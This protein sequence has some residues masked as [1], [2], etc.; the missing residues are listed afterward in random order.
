MLTIFRKTC[1]RETQA[2]KVRDPR[3][4]RGRRVQWFN[5]C[6]RCEGRFPALPPLA[7]RLKRKAYERRSGQL[8]FNV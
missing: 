3:P 6:R 7:A 2:D 8:S 5:L 1:N 4:T